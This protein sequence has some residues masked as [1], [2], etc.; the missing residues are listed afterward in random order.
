[1]RGGDAKHRVSTGA[2]A[3]GRKGALP[4]GADLCVCPD[5]GLGRTRRFAPT[6]A[7]AIMEIIL[8]I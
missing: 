7:P 8:I 4:V 3:I 1:M 2:G 6:D 5:D